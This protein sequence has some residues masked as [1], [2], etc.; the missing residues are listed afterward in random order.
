MT[1]TYDDFDCKIFDVAAL[2]HLSKPN[3]VETSQ[4][5]AESVLVKFIHPELQRL[6]IA[7]VV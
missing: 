4:E 5:Y 1:N 3:A 2:V 6:N 7:D